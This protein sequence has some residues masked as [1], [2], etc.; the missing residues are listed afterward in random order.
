LPLVRP[1]HPTHTDANAELEVSEVFESIQGEGVSAGQPCVFLRLAM[2]NLRCRWC[3]TRYTWDFDAFDRAREVTTYPVA[4]LI[5]SLAR[6]PAQRVV[7]TGGEPLLQQAALEALLARLNPNLAVEV[8][9]NGTIEPELALVARVDQWNVSPKLSNSGDPETARVR[10]RALRALRDTRRA[11]LKLVV[12]NAADLAEADELIA[13]LDWPRD[14]VLL[15]PRAAN[16]EELRDNGGLVARAAM[17][18][19]YRFSPRLHIELWG[20]QRGT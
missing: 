6:S 5:D 14:K 1:T 20:G 4:A 9:T 10:P 16:R 15:M 19:G 8:E 3:D 18:R 7:I 2:C 12:A 11:W 17:Q 13:R